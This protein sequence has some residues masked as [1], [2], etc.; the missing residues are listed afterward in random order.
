[1]VR[2]LIVCAAGAVAA[3]GADTS[4]EERRPGRA[5]PDEMQAPPTIAVP[6]N[7]VDREI[8]RDLNQAIAGDPDLRNRE[9]SFIVGNGD[10]SVTGTVRSE[11][12]RKKFNNLA[13][14][15]GGVKSVANNLRVEE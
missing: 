3:C 5:V 14:N 7:A 4:T 10:I 15:I 8:R 6:Q 13:M 9:I 1:M 12:E 11:D 2:L